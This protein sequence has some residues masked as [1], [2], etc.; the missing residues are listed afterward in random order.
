MVG[1]QQQASDLVVKTRLIFIDNFSKEISKLSAKKF[2]NL[3]SNQKIFDCLCITIQTY[4]T[5]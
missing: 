4:S 5:A 1:L 3:S 2:E